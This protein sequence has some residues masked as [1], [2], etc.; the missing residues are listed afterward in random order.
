[1][2]ELNFEGKKFISSKRAGILT[3]YTNDYIGQLCRAG[4]VNAKTVGRGWY[5]EEVSILK[6]KNENQ[7]IQAQNSSQ[8]PIPTELEDIYADIPDDSDDG[9]PVEIKKVNGNTA[10]RQ[11]SSSIPYRIHSISEYAPVSETQNR[12]VSRYERDYRPLI[13]QPRKYDIKQTS[14]Y[15]ES[16]KPKSYTGFALIVITVIAI[17]AVF[18]TLFLESVYQYANGADNSTAS[19][20]SIIK[21]RN[22]PF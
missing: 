13:P 21:I 16:P 12:N 5:V 2:E 19:I 11:V 10:E 22:L 15:L 8:Q 7:K 20:F 14:D 17:T 18:S 9:D 3:G 4:K 6:H 1:M